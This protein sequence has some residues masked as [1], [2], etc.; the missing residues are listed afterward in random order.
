MRVAFVAMALVI[1]AVNAANADCLEELGRV[2][3]QVDAVNAAKPT[4]QSQAA[5][6]ELQK[7]EHDEAA[8]EVDCYNT[9]ARAR[10]ALTAPL[11]PPADDRYARE[12][13]HQ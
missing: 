10:H 8:D 5:A 12:Q 11:P 4:A 1:G 9:L 13:R 3:E 6:R 2:R 7:L